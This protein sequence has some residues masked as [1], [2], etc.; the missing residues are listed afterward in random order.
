MAKEIEKYCPLC[1]YKLNKIKEKKL[2]CPNTRNC[3]YQCDV[4]KSDLSL[5]HQQMLYFKRLSLEREFELIKSSYQKR[6][7]LLTKWI[8]A[9]K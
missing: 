4:S 2:S 3:N 5:T 6:I 1:F 9:A 7:R 8:E